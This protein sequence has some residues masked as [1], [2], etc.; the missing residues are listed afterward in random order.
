MSTKEQRVTLLM[1][2]THA[3]ERKKAGEQITVPVGKIPWLQRHGVVAKPNA[4]KPRAG[5]K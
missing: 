3:G 1:P 5:D 2:H 4:E